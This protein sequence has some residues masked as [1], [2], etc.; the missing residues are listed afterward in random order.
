MIMS[1][2]QVALLGSTGLLCL[3]TGHYENK[4]IAQYLLLVNKAQWWEPRVREFEIL[5]GVDKDKF[6]SNAENNSIR[7]KSSWPGFE[8]MTLGFLAKTELRK[9]ALEKRRR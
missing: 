6:H 4:S 3:P 5:K 9:F 7:K 8:L 2:R 1:E